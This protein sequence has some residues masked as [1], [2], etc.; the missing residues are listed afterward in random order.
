MLLFCYNVLRKYLILVS[1]EGEVNMNFIEINFLKRK[2]KN[3]VILDKRGIFYNAFGDDAK[4]VSTITGYNINNNQVGFPINNLEKVVSML[5]SSHV[6]VYVD[7]MFFDFGEDYLIYLNLHSDKENV[8]KLVSE[9]CNE[10]RNIVY[11][12][13]DTYYRIK[14]ALDD[15]RSKS[16]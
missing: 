16:I 3:T 14:D 10:V 8:D 1:L 11:N 12:D 2:Y 9:L 4:V 13:G 7:D 15:I 6:S 5:S